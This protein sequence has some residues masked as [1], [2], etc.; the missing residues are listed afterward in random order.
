MRLLKIIRQKL[1]SW[2]NTKFLILIHQEMCNTELDETINNQ[3]LGV[4]GLMTEI[5]MGIVILLAILKLS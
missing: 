1:S 4:E 5:I 3:I 2:S